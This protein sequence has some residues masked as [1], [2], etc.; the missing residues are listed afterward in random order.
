MEFFCINILFSAQLHMWH[1]ISMCHF[2][3]F[4]YSLSHLLY[5]EMCDIHL[6]GKTGKI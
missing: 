2:T 5:G 3:L 1:F 6:P 4:D